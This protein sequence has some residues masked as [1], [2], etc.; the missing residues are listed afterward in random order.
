MKKHGL[1]LAVLLCVCACAAHAEKGTALLVVAQEGGRAWTKDVQEAVAALNVK[2]GAE[3]VVGAQDTRALNAAMAK[4]S[5]MTPK[6]IAVVP[7][8]L[9]SYDVTLA[10]ARYYFGVI[11]RMPEDSGKGLRLARA[12]ARTDVVFTQAMDGDDSVLASLEKELKAKKKTSSFSRLLV[13]ARSSAAEKNDSKQQSD[14]SETVLQMKT[15]LGLAQA[16]GILLKDVRTLPEEDM[17]FVKTQAR[18]YSQAGRLCVAFYDTDEGIAD[19]TAEPALEGVFYSRCGTIRPGKEA[20]E[21]FLKKRFAEAEKS[22]SNRR[23]Y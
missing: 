15:D 22:R 9:S 4:L 16:Q 6:K 19:K 11:E 2:D 17:I 8:F 14:L 20:I 10:F 12:Q 1:L 23:Y 18:S 7:L 13:F 3:I 5:A 21:S